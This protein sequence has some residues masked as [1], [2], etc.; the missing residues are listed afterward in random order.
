MPLFER[1]TLAA[2]TEVVLHQV[3]CGIQRSPA[4]MVDLLEN[5]GL[6]PRLDLAVDARAVYDV[7]A[8]ADACDPQECSLKLHLI[9]ARDRL[10]QGIIRRLHRVD[11]RDMLADGLTKGGS[12]AR[13]SPIV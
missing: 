2:E 1:G 9:S 7:V 11:T 3:Y 5:G 8:A 4:E 12:F 13:I 10:A 6:Y